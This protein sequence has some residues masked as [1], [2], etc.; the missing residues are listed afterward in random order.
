VC[1]IKTFFLFRVFDKTKYYIVFQ[2]S[3]DLFCFEKL[4]QKLRNN[5]S[6]DCVA[7]E[8]KR[9]RF[10]C[11]RGSRYP[12]GGQMSE[13]LIDHTCTQTDNAYELTYL[14]Y[15]LPR[16][17]TYCLLAAANFLRP[18][19]QW[20]MVYCRKAAVCPCCNRRRL[21]NLAVPRGER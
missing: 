8:I 19:A 3:D 21:R 7:Q 10:F 14:N 4:S 18:P 15:R 13:N 1:S 20:Q 6:G 11:L 9:H 5:D 17:L 16:R 2:R 12:E